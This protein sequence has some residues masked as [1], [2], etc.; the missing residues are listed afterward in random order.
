ML[1]VSSVASLALV[2]A[3]ASSVSAASFKFSQK[4]QA[5]DGN[6]GL[7]VGLEGLFDL[8]EVQTFKFSYA[9]N[10]AYFGAIKYEQYSE[11]LVLS[12]AKVAGDTDG[13]LS[14]LSI[15]SAPTGYQYG[16]ILPD[17]TAPLQFTVPHTGG[18]M[19]DNA[20]ATGF[21]FSGGGPL[22]YN[23]ENKFWACQNP[24]LKALESYQIW[25][26]GA[27]TFPLGVDC[28]GPIGADEIDPCQ[29]GN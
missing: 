19:P 15:H 23:G 7:S 26:N 17:E 12:G 20:V 3:A 21:S 29:R 14:F 4:R 6:F 11:P 13:G 24:E 2:A 27:G 16:Y 9:N 28:K 25:W 8:S 5:V 1:F 22:M 18:E 10:S